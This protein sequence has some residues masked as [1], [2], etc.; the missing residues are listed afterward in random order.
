VAF[1]LRW[2][3]AAADVGLVVALVAVGY[4]A[5]HRAGVAGVLIAGAA[6]PLVVRRRWPLVTLAATGTATIGYLLLGYPY[7]PIMLSVAVA[8]FSVAVSMPARPAGIAAAVLL[9]GLLV[10]AL[11]GP[12]PPG[13]VWV[14]VPFAGGRVVRA[15]REAAARVRGEEIQRYVYEERLRIAGEVHDV[16]GHGLAA[17]HLQAQVALHVLER[18]PEQ[19]GAALAA[20]GRSSRESLAELRATLAVV[21][22]GAA[23][24]GPG[25]ADLDGLVVRLAAAGLTVRVRMM[26]VPERL[27]AAVDL[28]AYRIVQEALTNVLRHAGTGRAQVSVCGSERE[29]AV[30]VRDAGVAVSVVEGGRGLAGMRSRAVALG[31][32]LWAGPCPG[33]GF[34]VYARLPVEVSS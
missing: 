1:L 13:W 12:V 11:V 16:V 22:G 32:D 8:V 7:G 20:I 28:A 27:P 21:G 2:R 15:G 4:V 6:V 3:A 31:G 33:G 26:G 5:A 10:P 30:E 29:V 9:G 34:R 23:G 25:L 24:A 18:R 17:V 19:A 14:V